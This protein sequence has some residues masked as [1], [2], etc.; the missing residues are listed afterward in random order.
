[1]FACPQ[2]WP[3][4][5]KYCSAQLI[6]QQ[7]LTDM[8]LMLTKRIA[9]KASRLIT[10]KY[11]RHGHKNHANQPRTVRVACCVSSCVIHHVSYMHVACCNLH[12][13]TK[14]ASKDPVQDSN[15]QTSR[16]TRRLPTV[17]RSLPIAR[18]CSREK[19]SG[20]VG[21]TVRRRSGGPKTCGSKPGDPGGPPIS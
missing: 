5:M 11:A 12:M 13:Y 16:T 1:M 19:L 3:C 8:T 14:T 20:S 2:P 21:R 17:P 4:A 9:L 15:L 18:A 10:G 7:N 6:K